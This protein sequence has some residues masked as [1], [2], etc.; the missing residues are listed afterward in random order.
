M[1]TGCFIFAKHTKNPKDG[2]YKSVKLEETTEEG[3]IL[4]RS[5]G[6]FFELLEWGFGS[7]LALT[8]LC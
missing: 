5:K 8:K 1:L 2:M 4:M 3:K 7:K 6:L